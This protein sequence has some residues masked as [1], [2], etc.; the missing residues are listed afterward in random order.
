MKDSILFLILLTLFFIDKVA[1]I[2]IFAQQKPHVIEWSKTYGGSRDD[3]ANGIGR[4]R[5]ILRTADG[6]YILAGVTNSRDGDIDISRRHNDMFQQDSFIN[7][8]IWIVKLSAGGSIEWEQYYGGE[9]TDLVNDMR[10]TSDGGYIL[11]GSTASFKGDFPIDT[12]GIYH[13]LARGGFPDGFVMKLDLLGRKEWVSRIGG[14]DYDEL[15]SVIPTSDGGYIATGFTHSTDELWLGLSWIS[16]LGKYYNGFAV[17]LG[18]DGTKK[19]NRLYGGTGRDYLHGVLEKH[20]GGYLLYASTNSADGDVSKLH[21][22]DSVNSIGVVFDVWIIEITNTGKII[23]E[24]CFGGSG[25]E[26]GGQILFANDGGFIISTTTGLDNPPAIVSTGDVVGYHPHKN[27]LIYDVSD[28]WIFKIDTAWNII[29][30]NCIGGSQQDNI[31]TLIPTRSGG[32]AFIGYT[33]S[34]DSD[35]TGIH[36]P[37]PEH[38]WDIWAGELSVDGKLL[39]HQCFGGT[40]RDYGNGIVE[41]ADGGF[42]LYASVASMD[43]DIIG[44]HGGTYPHFSDIWVAKLKQSPSSVEASSGGS[45]FANPYPNPSFDEM[46]LYIHPTQPPQTVQFFNPLGQELFPKYQVDGNLLTTDT[47]TLGKG[48][49]II[50][51]TYQDLSVQEVRKFVKVE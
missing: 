11:C 9:G 46:N 20:D 45:H 5:P 23:R 24:K 19:W 32:Y 48:M 35:L 26:G 29:W 33:N 36:K 28:S 25:N 47:R 18:P 41:N 51:I 15:S 10:A 39:W 13:I 6:G 34:S 38:N 2:N 49:Y 21:Y 8:D 44:H 14:S 3:N 1:P 42:T 12:T 30:Q 16:N 43:G 17:K 22:K 31:N 50:R 7:E 27:G 4:F 40:A 37:E